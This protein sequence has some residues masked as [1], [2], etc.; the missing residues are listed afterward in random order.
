MKAWIKM[1]AIV[2][3]VT[4]LTRFIPFADF[5][6]NVNTLIHELVHALTTLLLSG[7]VNHI[8][9]YADQSGITLSSY[10]EGWM[11]IPIA[12]AGYCGSSLFA[13]LLFRL[14]K[15]SKEIY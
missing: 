9:L 3:V 4:F 10:A 7:R 13:V 2:V 6:R 14:Y 5:F 12:L 1:L 11:T 15:D 8:H